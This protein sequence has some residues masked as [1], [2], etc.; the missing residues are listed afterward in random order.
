MGEIRVEVV[1]KSGRPG[2]LRAGALTESLLDRVEELGDS[3]MEVA[4]G[5]RRRIDDDTDP[6][7]GTLRL[8]EVSLTFSI[9]LEAEAGV[10]VSRA[11]AGA[12]FEVALT[13]SRD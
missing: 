6:E 2:D 3:I 7:L 8:N 10:I 4:R 9:D 13:W 11:S 12:G 1:P 5:L